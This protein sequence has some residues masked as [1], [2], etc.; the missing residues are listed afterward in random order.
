MYNMD[1]RIPGQV[2]APLG[3]DPALTFNKRAS[4]TK[5]EETDDKKVNDEIR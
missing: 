5:V 1:S 2:R 3:G 4:Y